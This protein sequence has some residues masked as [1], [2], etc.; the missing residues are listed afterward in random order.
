M[1]RDTLIAALVGALIATIPILISNIVQI[2]I[3]ISEKR[4]KE[5]EAK[6]NAKQKWI[7]HDI[8]KIIDSL[9]D[10]LKLVALY[11]DSYRDLS[12]IDARKNADLLTENEAKE[13]KLLLIQ[14]FDTSFNEYNQIEAVAIKQAYSFGEGILS[15]YKELYGLWQKFFAT[16][17]MPK[18]LDND[19]DYFDHE[20]FY[21]V[22]E[23]AGNLQ[24][25]LREKLISIRDSD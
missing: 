1:D 5:K 19:K 21:R 24:R 20:I 2:Y 6:I 10:L 11:R 3:H 13:E 22:C 7:E 8:R 12:I 23:S 9:D 16:V 4:Q 18:D 17:K 15:E 25:L 14:K